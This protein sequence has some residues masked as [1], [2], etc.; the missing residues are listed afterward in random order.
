M[1]WLNYHHLLYFWTVA[2]EGSVTAACERLR[3][4]QP[5]I[6]AQIRALERS[7]GRKLFDK[8]GR[9]LVLSEAGRM[10]FRYADEIFALGEE[11]SDALAGRPFAGSRRLV[12]GISDSLPKLIAYR[13]LVPAVNLP[14]P[15]RLIC[16]EDSPSQ[17]L[18]RL[19]LGDLDV[20]LSDAPADPHVKVRAF[21]HL[22][23]ECA[24]SVFASRA[25]ASKYRPRFPQSLTGAPML[26]PTRDSILRRSLDRWFD[27][28]GVRPDV[29]AEMQ[30]SALIKRFGQ[31]GLGLFV[32][33]AAIEKDIQRQYEVTRIGRIDQ[34][35]EQ[36]YAISV[37]RK[38]RHP[39]VAAI[40]AGSHRVFG[41]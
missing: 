1:A 14:E 39:A 36:Y 9:G 18:A 4:T 37:E 5:T 17:L 34:V 20:V 3:L 11:L 16:L 21:N 13:L 25:L 12:V 24:M 15:V 7:F 8:A 2:K 28:C 41:P 23:G 30:D 40:A 27:A 33:P 35:R 6:S 31:A 19:S 26:L 22:L 38:V 29:V 32:A 10:V